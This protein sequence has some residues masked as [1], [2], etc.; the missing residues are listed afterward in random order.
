MIIT[1]KLSLSSF[2]LG[3]PGSILLTL[4]EPSTAFSVV[5]GWISVSKSRTGPSFRRGDGLL[6]TR[7]ESFRSGGADRRLLLK[8]ST[9]PS[10]S[11]TN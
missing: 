9:K 1:T 2:N 4:E 10:S 3:V 7:R 11:S 5:P 6:M 8:R